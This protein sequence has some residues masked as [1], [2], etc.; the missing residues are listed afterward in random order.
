[1]TARPGSIVFNSDAAEL[2]FAKLLRDFVPLNRI[3]A[4]IAWQH[5]EDGD[6]NIDAHNVEIQ[7]S[8]IEISV[9]AGLVLPG[10]DTSPSLMLTAQFDK[11]DVGQISRYLPV[12]KMRPGLVRWVDRALVSGQIRG[13]TVLFRGP[14]QAFPFDNKEGRFEVRFSVYDAILEYA[15]GWPRLE[16]LEGDLAFDGRSLSGTISNGVSFHSEIDEAR[17]LIKNLAAKPAILSVHGRAHGPTH[18]AVRYVIESPL[19]KTFGGYFENTKVT[20]TSKLDLELHLPLAAHGPHARVRGDL[21]MDNSVMLLAGGDVDIRK[22]NGMLHF[23]E[24]GLKA[25]GIKAQIMGLPAL[26]SIHEEQQDREKLTLFRATGRRS[27]T[28]PW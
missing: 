26:V 20:G 12:S 19:N 6:W 1:M 18:D 17:L 11:G 7:N 23:T 9:N 5:S 16:E 22:I 15:K 3:R 21:Q 27:N 2:H 25:D 14:L 24:S 10:G 4:H 8:D 13:G 28:P